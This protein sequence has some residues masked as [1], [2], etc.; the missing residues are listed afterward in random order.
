MVRRLF[1]AGQ[2]SFKQEV[3]FK[4]HFMEYSRDLLGVL[5]SILLAVT[6]AVAEGVVKIPIFQILHWPI[7]HYAWHHD[8]GQFGQMVECSFTN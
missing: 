8:L 4:S 6:W 3:I 7:S 5:I 1:S 2:I